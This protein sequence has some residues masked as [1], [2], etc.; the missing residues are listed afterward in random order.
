MSGHGGTGVGT[1]FDKI[2]SRADPDPKEGKDAKPKVHDLFM[3]VCRDELSLENFSEALYGWHN[4]MLTQAAVRLLQSID[5]QSGRL[6]FAQFQRAL[7]EDDAPLDGGAGLGIKYADQASAIIMDNCGAPIPGMTVAQGKAL[8]DISADSF[9]RAKQRVQVMQGRGAFN[10][11]PVMKTNKPSQGNPMNQM[12]RAHS[13]PIRGAM[14]AMKAAMAE[15]RE[16]IINATREFVGGDIPRREYESVLA[17]AGIPLTRES[18]LQK[19][20]LS[21]DQVGDGNFLQMNKALQRLTGAASAR[22]AS[23]VH[24]NPSAGVANYG[25]CR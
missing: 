22:S 14:G 25:N 8:T 18:E 2:F 11:N 3:S 12:D 23:T 15:D 4:I 24:Q 20:I 9:V 17:Q 7:Q 19:L 5:A 6:S 21:H 13:P 16:V 1:S 10:S